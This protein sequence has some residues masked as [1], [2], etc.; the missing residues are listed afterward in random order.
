MSLLI[1]TR[2]VMGAIGGYIPRGYLVS[3]SPEKCHYGSR[4]NSGFTGE[5]MGFDGMAEFK[6]SVNIFH[7]MNLNTGECFVLTGLSALDALESVLI[8]E[9]GKHIMEF[10]GFNE[11]ERTY[12]CADFAVLKRPFNEF[13]MGISK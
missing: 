2:I 3:K 4:V 6:D 12:E 5:V 10:G 11:G 13:G 1:T 7:C 9:T 8:A